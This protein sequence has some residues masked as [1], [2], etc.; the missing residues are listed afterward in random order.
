[1]LTNAEIIKMRSNK[2]HIYY[3]NGAWCVS[4]FVINAGKPEARAAIDFVH[5]KNEEI[6]RH[7]KT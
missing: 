4:V 7:E 3:R 1:M 2:P 6:R 5:R